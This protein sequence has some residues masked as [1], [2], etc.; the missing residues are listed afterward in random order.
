MSH[1]SRSKNKYRSVKKITI[2]WTSFFLRCKNTP[3][4]HFWIKGI[5]KAIS[6]IENSTYTQMIYVSHHYINISLTYVKHIHKFLYNKYVLIRRLSPILRT[7]H[8]LYVNK[9]NFGKY[10]A[11]GFMPQKSEKIERVGINFSAN[12]SCTS[13]C[14]ISVMISISYC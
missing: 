6:H 4:V 10:A 14:Y 9:D 12:Y 2:K 1:K 8:F 5:L 11:L 13:L 3:D 7:L